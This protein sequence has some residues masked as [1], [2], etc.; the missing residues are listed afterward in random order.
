MVSKAS[1]FEC[2]NNDKSDIEGR[3]YIA[4]FFI[5]RWNLENF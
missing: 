4:L 2:S 3:L 1:F 5:R